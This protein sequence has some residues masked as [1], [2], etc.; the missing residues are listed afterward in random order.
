MKDFVAQVLLLRL[1][2]FRRHTSRRPLLCTLSARLPFVTV[3]H[4]TVRG[5]LLLLGG[6]SQRPPVRFSSFYQLHELIDVVHL[7][8]T[9][10]SG[11]L[12]HQLQVWAG[13]W[14]GWSNLRYLTAVSLG[15]A[16]VAS[17]ADAGCVSDRLC[18]LCF[19][20]LEHP[21]HIVHQRGCEIQ[22]GPRVSMESARWTGAVHQVRCCNRQ[23]DAHVSSHALPL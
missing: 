7:L 12:F 21:R 1:E 16:F 6:L 19:G 8:P 23:D 20:V 17:C 22:S 13:V 18:F 2:I 3:C 15:P 11:T 5:L 14:H 10:R 4:S 9:I